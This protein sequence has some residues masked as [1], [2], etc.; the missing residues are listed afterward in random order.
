MVRVFGLSPIRVI[1]FRA[2]A[3]AYLTLLSATG[4]DRWIDRPLNELGINRRDDVVKAS[5]LR[6]YIAPVD[7]SSVSEMSGLEVLTTSLRSLPANRQ[8]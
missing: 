6:K 8:D 3:R 4:P 7:R 1:Q 5:I 2:P